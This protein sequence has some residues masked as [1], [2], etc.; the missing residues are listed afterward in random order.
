VRFC[1]RSLR[2]NDLSG[3]VPTELGLLTVLGTLNLASN[4]LSGAVPT[5]LGLLTALRTLSL[6]GNSLS[7]ALPSELG[8]IP[9]TSCAL[10]STYSEANAFECPAPNALSRFC[11]DG[12]CGDAPGMT[13]CEHTPSFCDGNYSGTSLWAAHNPHRP[14]P[15]GSLMRRLLHALRG[16][17]SSPHCVRADLTSPP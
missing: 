15:H 10:V 5:E 16:A 8:L 3:A 2:S 17:N 11:A 7:G 14:A 6:A 12:L 4:D 9:L 1:H 13:L